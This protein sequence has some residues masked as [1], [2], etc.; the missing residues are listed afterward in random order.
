MNQP[1]MSQPELPE[2]SLWNILEVA[3]QMPEEADLGQLW[4]A[5]EAVLTGLNS[6]EQLR[7]VAEAIAQI[8]ALFQE[9]SSLVFEDLQANTADEGPVM[10]VDA[11]DRYVR[12]TMAVDFERFIE[13]LPGLPRKPPERQQQTDGEE[14]VVGVVEKE[15]LL[16][17]LEA[18]LDPQEAFEQAMAIAHDEEVSVWAGVIADYLSQQQGDRVCLEELRQ[19]L[20]LSL[21]EIWLGLLLG[22][23]SLWAEAATAH[24]A[25]SQ[26]SQPLFR[27]PGYF[28]PTEIWVEA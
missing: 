8:T 25:V 15:V 20:P 28:Y 13:P 14:S 18:V 1:A 5:L 12:Q 23:F 26:V 3:T 7:V 19:A 27:Q 6:A 4:Q 2:I 11:F 24:N 16:E 10:P 22:G 21:I 17:V 9:R